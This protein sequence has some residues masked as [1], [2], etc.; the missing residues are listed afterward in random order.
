MIVVADTSPLNYLVR[1]G[2]ASVLEPLYAR[3]IVPET[4]AAEMKQPRTPAQV[5]AWIENP[6]AW[7]DIAPDPPPDASL[8]ALDPGE[9]AAIGLA[10]SLKAHRLLIDDADG[11]AEAER[12]Q[13]RVTGTLGVLA[14]AHRKGLLDFDNAIELLSNTTFYVSPRLLATARRLLS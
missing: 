8:D 3:V 4:V 12:R 7:L 9:R 13:L 6:P 10:I 5:R 11:R 14:A 1:I 2:A